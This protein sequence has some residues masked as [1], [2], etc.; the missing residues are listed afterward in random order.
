[1][2]ASNPTGSGLTGSLR[3]VGTTLLALVSARAELISIELQEQKER[4]GQKIVFGLL[5]SLF[6]AVGLALAAFLVIM[7][8][9]DTYRLSAAGCVTVLYLGIGGWAVLRLQE[10]NR[11]SPP[12]FSATLAE[13]AS[14]LKHLRGSDE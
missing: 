7:M 4:A 12:P 14:D 3:T 2:S 10:M 1:M 13:F 9:W 8:F 6:L 11:N 5:A